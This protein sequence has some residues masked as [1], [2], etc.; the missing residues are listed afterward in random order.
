[1]VWSEQKSCLIHGDTL[2]FLSFC[3]FLGEIWKSFD[4]TYCYPMKKKGLG[5]RPGLTPVSPTS[6]ALFL[7][8]IPHYAPSTC[9]S[10]VKSLRSLGCV[11]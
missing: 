9:C 7:T 2:E 11:S 8:Y 10:Y 5:L 4:S 6:G 3:S 1:M